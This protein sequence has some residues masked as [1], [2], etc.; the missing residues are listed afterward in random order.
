MAP[1]ALK[2]GEIVKFTVF[3]FDPSKDKAPYYVEYEVPYRPGMTVLDGLLYILEELDPTLSFR[4]SCRSKICGSC[5]MMINGVQRLAC[6]TQI[7]ELGKRIKVE[8]LAHFAIIRDL[9]V[10]MEPFLRQMEAIMPYLY[11]KEHS[12]E[13][14]VDPK[15]FEKYKSPSDCIW[16][17]ACVSACPVAS[18]DPLFLGPAALTQLYR[19]AV[20]SREREDVKPLRLLIADSEA[21]GVWR[22]H[23]VYA[24]AEVC[25]K[26]IKPGSVIA[27]LKRMTLKARLVGKI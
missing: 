4:Y 1:K 11:P 18:T 2:E 10:D 20:D 9:V 7:S 22:C 8:P 6:E 27:E 25:P 12:S 13:P 21:S 16:C 15:E 3:R 24:C 26:H 14:R 17:G 5:A 19:F 23:Q